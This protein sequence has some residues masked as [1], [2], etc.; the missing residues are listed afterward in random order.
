MANILAVDDSSSMRKMV[1]FTLRLAGHDVD[2]AGDGKHAL[3]IASQKQF[4]LVLTD[5]NMPVMDGLNLTRELRTIPEYR[6]TPIV[7]LTTEAG[8]DKKQAGREAGATGW[9]VKP[10]SSEQLLSLVEKVLG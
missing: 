1:A 9:L 8:L 6:S 4:D 5:L 7:V 10:F 3:E 2:E